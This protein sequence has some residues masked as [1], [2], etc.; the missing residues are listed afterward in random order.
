M[1]TISQPFDL[2]SQHSPNLYHGYRA[3]SDN[4][5]L[6]TPFPLTLQYQPWIKHKQRFKE[7]QS[8][9]RLI[10]K[11][12]LNRRRLQSIPPKTSLIT[13]PPIT[14][15]TPAQKSTFATYGYLV[16][17]SI[18]SP[19]E[20][21]A[22]QTWAQEIHD[23]P[24]TVDCKYLQYDEINSAG[25]RVLCRTENFCKG[26][27]GFNKLLRG[28]DEKGGKF[29]QILREVFGEEMVLFKEKSKCH[30]RILTQSKCRQEHSKLQIFRLRRIQ[31]TY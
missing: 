17:S 12:H 18:F 30:I 21:L 15:L 2:L 31:T 28:N 13:P 4:T 20:L 14:T 1:A 9:K 10:Q 7:L 19:T 8:T 29:G 6:T 16:V 11:L 26:H 23:L 3:H 25:E 5:A 22:L 27:A 24:R